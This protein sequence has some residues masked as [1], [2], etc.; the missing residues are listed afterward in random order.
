MIDKGRGYREMLRLSTVGLT[1][2]F[3][4]GIGAGGG[5]WL[6]NHFKTTPIC[7]IIGF[8]LGV[9]A[10]IKELIRVLKIRD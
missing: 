8:I 9:G 4:I 10:A 1:V 3:A 6:D 7:T 2:A 5:I